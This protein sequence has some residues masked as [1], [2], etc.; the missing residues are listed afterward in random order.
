MHLS[1]RLVTSPTVHLCKT[2]VIITS[3][4]NDPSTESVPTV[5]SESRLCGTQAAPCPAIFSRVKEVDDSVVLGYDAASLVDTTFLR[6]VGCRLHIPE[7]RSAQPHRL[8]EPVKTSK[9]I[10]TSLVMCRFQ[11][12]NPYRTNVENRVSS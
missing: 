6:N 11:R 2:T 8:E 1:V 7:G 3:T 5:A 12:I 10:F 9:E 4:T